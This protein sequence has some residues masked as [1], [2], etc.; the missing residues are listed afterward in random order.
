MDFMELL[1]M[2]SLAFVIALAVKRRVAFKIYWLP[3]RH[4]WMAVAFGLTAF[5]L[6]CSLLTFAPHSW[7][8]TAI[9]YIGIWTVCGFALPWFYVALIERSGLSGM[10]GH[11]KTLEAEPQAVLVLVLMVLMGQTLAWA[12]SFVRRPKP[13]SDG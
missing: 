5:G 4:T 13:G 9:N 6:S 2:A 3:E 8:R 12:P 7:I 10:G 11:P 1:I